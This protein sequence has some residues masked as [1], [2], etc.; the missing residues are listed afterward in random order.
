MRTKLKHIAERALVESGALRFARRRLR[1]SVI[2]LAYHNIVPNGE[3]QEG[4]RSL[5]LPIADFSRQLDAISATHDVIAI[6]GVLDSSRDAT[7]PRAVIT[8][9]D[10]YLGAMTA[11]ARELASRGLPATIFVAP[12]LLGRFT[13]WDAMADP[14]L[15]EIDSR[16]RELALTVLGGD[17]DLVMSEPENQNSN[18]SVLPR[19]CDE[20]DLDA[21]SRLDGI[22][23]GSHS[24]SHPNLVTLSDPDLQNEMVNPLSWLRDRFSCTIPWISY[25]YGQSDDRVVEAAKTAGYAA[26]F[27]IEGGYLSAGDTRSSR[28]A[29]GRLNVPA[30][31]SIDGF[32]IRLAGMH[33]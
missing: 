20:S 4:E 10:A 8:F 3:R 2:V 6:G 23:F 18:P 19:I 1:G 30:G 13:W 31:I 24:W 11:G 32:R 21:A 22:T 14:V 16:K 17:T 12:G 28:F 5:H 25:P 27:R 7:R 15:G 9:D 29:L 33:Q 26:G